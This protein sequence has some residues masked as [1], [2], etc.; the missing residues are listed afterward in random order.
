M[1]VSSHAEF[2]ERA[3]EVIACI[4]RS[5]CAVV[6]GSESHDAVYANELSS[7]LGLP[8]IGPEGPEI[9]QVS[10]LFVLEKDAVRL[11]KIL[12]LLQNCSNVTVLAYETEFYFK[13]RPVFVQS[14]PKSGTH[15]LVQCMQAFGYR[16]PLALEFPESSTEFEPGTYYS[17]QHMTTDFLSDVYRNIGKFVRAYSQSPVVC[18][19]RDPRDI[20]VSL[21][22]YLASQG[23]YHILSL[24]M[25]RM[26]L[27][28]RISTVIL[29]S[30]KIPVY[31]NDS[32]RFRGTISD[33]CETYRTW[34]D[35]SW[36]NCWLTRFEDLVGP[37][38]GGTS[39]DQMTAI[40]GLQ[41]A[42]HV[43]GSPHQ[44]IDAIFNPKS[45]TF[46]SGKIFSFLTNFSPDQH[47]LFRDTTA[48][49][50]SSM[51]YMDLVRVLRS[52]KVTFS[53]ADVAISRKTAD[54]LHRFLGLH[55]E[56]LSA[57]SI[58]EDG[59][60][61][62]VSVQHCASVL[63]CP[64]GAIALRCEVDDFPSVLKFLELSSVLEGS[65]RGCGLGNMR[66]IGTLRCDG[67]GFAEQ[68][69]MIA[70]VLVESYRGYNI[71]KDASQQKPLYMAICMEAGEMDL[72]SVF[73]KDLVMLEE[74]KMLFITESVTLARLHID[75]HV[76]SN[77][78]RQY[79]T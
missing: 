73:R 30:Y 24:L 16:S 26:S 3:S 5:V 54:Q 2:V 56:N 57:L 4:G 43:P 51:G 44:Y 12:L 50:A 1:F 76:V 63:D 9:C 59:D 34:W 41:L 35:G 75:L 31:I 60:M 17:L 21:A 18:I 62:T 25:Q 45:P 29:G 20:A 78:V 32:F 40:W 14:I 69:A 48:D 64:G 46:R 77:Q 52:F 58:G 67:H 7:L 72:T 38:G 28:D 37:Y 74:S 39:E 70:P 23:D 8:L 68:P 71:V 22:H 66:Y 79:C 6:P 55:A 42:L 11:T 13:N 47:N 27:H 61:V 53:V 49:V 65:V 33:L 15:L 19:V 10:G 36:Q